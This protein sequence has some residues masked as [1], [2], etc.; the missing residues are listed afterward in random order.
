MH[1]DIE[2]LIPP[3]STAVS[4]D[5]IAHVTRDAGL[6]RRW[7]LWLKR[8]RVHD[9]RIRRRFSVVFSVLTVTAVL[10]YAFRG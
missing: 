10:L 2:L 4:F 5:P 9:R 8:G 7:V 1:N 3:P 6:N